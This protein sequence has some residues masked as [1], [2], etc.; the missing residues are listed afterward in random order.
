MNLLQLPER[1]A[2][3][4]HRAP[5]DGRKQ[6]NGL[7]L[8]VQQ[9]MKHSAFESALF[10][11]TP[12]SRRQIKLLYWARNGFC[13]WQKRLEQQRFPWPDA[14]AEDVMTLTERE[15]DWLLRGI[16]FFHLK[17]HKVLH[18]ASVG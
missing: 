8:I 7:S 18:F 1:M 2:I 13:L 17:P 10:V 5:V 4:L 3:Y 6:I 9:E 15:L 16:D 14:D 11:F 12:R